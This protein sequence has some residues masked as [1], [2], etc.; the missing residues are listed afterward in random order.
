VPRRRSESRGLPARIATLAALLLLRLWTRLVRR[1]VDSLAVLLAGAACVMIVVNALVLQSSALPTPFSAVPPPQAAAGSVRSKAAQP[2]LQPPLYAA[3]TSPAPQRVVA[4]RN[5]PIAQ[6]IGT[7]SRILAVQ[8]ALSEYGYGQIRPSGVL[9]RPTSAA[10]E[11]FERERKL[12][13]TG[14]ISDRLVSDLSA[15]V[16]HPLE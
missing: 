14:R 13:V 10:I 5:D 11:R 2:Q 3:E 4:R 1:P 16:G 7:S 12:P 9:D 6:L 15:M 8:R